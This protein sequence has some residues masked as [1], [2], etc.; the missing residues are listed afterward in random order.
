[1]GENSAINKKKIAK[2]TGLL[3]FRML[4]SLLVSLYTSRVI[5][6]ALGVE[7]F[8]IYGVVSSVITLF[9]F[10]NA[11]MSGATSRFFT[12]HLGRDSQPQLRKTFSASLSIHLLI[13]LIVVVLSE[14]VGLWLLENKM[15]IPTERMNA[16]RWV[17]HL[18]TIGVVFSIISVPYN[19]AIIAHERMN[20][21]A[22][23]EIFNTFLR[24]GI[25]YLLLVTGGDKLITYATLSLT[26]N[27]LIT[28][29]YRWYCLRNYKE[30]KF[31]FNWDKSIIYPILSFS[32][33]D[34]FGNLG[35]MARTQGV[36]VLLNL[37]FGPLLNAANSIAMQVQGAVMNFG[38]N[39][40]IA[41]R[42]QI[43]KTYAVGEC[44]NSCYLVYNTAKFTFLLLLVLSLPLILEI[45]YILALWLGTVP[46]YT[47]LFCQC[48]LIFNLFMIMSSAVMSGIYATGKNRWPNII[49]GTLSLLILPATFIAFK[50]GASPYFPYV[51]NVVFSFIMLFSNAYILKRHLPHFQLRRFF[52]KVIVTCL[53]I[54]ILAFLF[55]RYIQTLMPEGLL[56]LVVI[57]LSSSVSIFTLSYFFAVDK[58]MKI[59]IK[60]WVKNRWRGGRA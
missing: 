47:A 51:L 32:A 15:V 28:S 10:L 53:T 6:S 45:D 17:F 18:S 37:F 48:T 36:N 43:V 39:I 26:V 19:A 27:I 25:V 52:F 14:T 34:L 23:V 46:E 1:M 60:N 22:Y 9:T 11:G 55:T 5:L 7:D 8:G 13:A 50:F 30:C 24:L 56:R 2:N 21:Y 59:F 42:P 16:A 33:W 57:I 38:N 12:F 49:S 35:Y 40:L 54:A 41:T 58:S 3:Y 31:V 20:I 4:V 44:E 29:I